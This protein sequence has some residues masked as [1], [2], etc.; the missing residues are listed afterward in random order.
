METAPPVRAFSSR[1]AREDATAAPRGIRRVPLVLASRTAPRPGSDRPEAADVVARHP[2]VLA[3]RAPAA[4]I[5]EG[6]PGQQVWGGRMA[7]APPV[8]A[9]PGAG[10]ASA[11]V[12]RAATRMLEPAVAER[13]VEDVIRRVDRRMRIER[14]RRGL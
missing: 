10:V 6:T 8:A 13:L 5:G 1:H 12:D 2:V 14:E 4:E 11:A 7:G 3:W 9:A